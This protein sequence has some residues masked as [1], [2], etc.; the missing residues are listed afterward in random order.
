VPSLRIIYYVAEDFSLPE[1]IEYVEENF[2]FPGYGN[3]WLTLPQGGLFNYVEED[4]SL[5]WVGLG[6]R[7]NLQVFIRS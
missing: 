6:K 3:R 5:P 2:S 1:D 4:F 7:A